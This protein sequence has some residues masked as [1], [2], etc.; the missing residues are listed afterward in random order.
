ML[1]ENGSVQIRSLRRQQS[2]STRLDSRAAGILANFYRCSL[3]PSLQA[4]FDIADPSSSIRKSHGDWNQNRVTSTSMRRVVV[5]LDHLAAPSHYSCPEDVALMILSVFET[6]F[7][8]D[9]AFRRFPYF[10]PRLRQLK[11]YLDSHRPHTLLQLWRDGRPSLVVDLLGRVPL[12]TVVHDQAG[13]RSVYSLL[14][15]WN[16]IPEF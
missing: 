16:M 15:N 6:D 3:P 2:T 13:F 9:E 8:H 10:G 5:L 1:I 4:A 14:F 11:T 12:L 7:Q